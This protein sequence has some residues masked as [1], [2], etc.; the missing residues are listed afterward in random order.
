MRLKGIAVAFM[1]L[2]SASAVEVGED[3]QFALLV[4]RSLLVR[5]LEREQSL[6]VLFT[7]GYP[8]DSYA[9]GYMAGRV[10][11]AREYLTLLDNATK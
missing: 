7:S 8:S 10:A 2:A 1:F 6:G 5:D 9:V 3:T 4:R 11:K